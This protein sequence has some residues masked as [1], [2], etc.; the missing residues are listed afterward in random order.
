MADE[1]CDGTQILGE[2]SGLGKEAV[3]KIWGEVKAN[4][5]ALAGCVGPHQFS[6]L[7]GTGLEHGRPSRYVCAR[8][9]GVVGLEAFDWY[10][11]GFAHGA[12]RG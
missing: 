7:A 11:K 4:Q 2:V 5:A 8:C 1:T 12:T 6:Q 9:G 10:L 3:R